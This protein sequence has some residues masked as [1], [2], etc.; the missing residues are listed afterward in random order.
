MQVER[1]SPVLLLLLA[2]VLVAVV[3]VWALRP[4]PAWVQGQ[5][6]ATQVRVAAKLPGR[7]E[8]LEV[9]E[10]E[11]VRAGQLLVR[12]ATPEVDA[13][14]R[15][16]DALVAA[17]EAQ[18][19]KARSGAREEQVL[20]ARAQWQAAEQQ[21]QLAATTHA[22][23]ERLHQDGVVPTQKR[24]EAAA[25]ARAARAQ[26][27][28]AREAYRMTRNA[29]RPEDLRAADAQ[30]AQA[31]G[32]REEVQVALDEGRVLAPVDG[33]VAT[34]AV[35][36]GEV[37][38][39]GAPLLTLVRL[40]DPWLTLNLRED[41]LPGVRM[42]GELVGRVPA[43][44]GLE[45]RFIVD[46]IAPQADFATWRSTRDLG[47]FDLRTFEVR[48]RPAS[49]VEG[50]RPGMGVLLDEHTLRRPGG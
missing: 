17:A 34:R 50:L 5:I 46:Y 25:M 20:I 38:A 31:R 4:R 29:T 22:R 24:D 19:D 33:E 16:A 42:G 39:A 36:P 13:R 7:I 15:Q 41:L 49:P 47:G 1:R 21:A 30:L 10:G 3:A 37:V 28:A 44:G 26:A 6:E 40:D 18:A 9:G 43:L 14:A 45:A 2:V 12:M 48:A 8:A 35:E 11:A 23:I 32:G 27:D